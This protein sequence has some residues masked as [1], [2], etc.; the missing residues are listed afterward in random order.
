MS[1]PT[2]AAVRAALDEIVDPCSRAAGCVTGLD[3]LG[4]VRK[5]SLSPGADGRVDVQVVIGV[6]EYGC[7]MGASFASEAYKRLTLLPGIG[8][9]DVALDDAFDW[10]PADM[11]PAYAKRLE[12]HRATRWMTINAVRPAARTIPITAASNPPAV[13]R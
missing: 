11:A 6:T 10:D 2:E 4:L 7:L 5:V 13:S 9:I 1:G 3:S 8:A 12:A